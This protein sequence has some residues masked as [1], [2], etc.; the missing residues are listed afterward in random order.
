[1]Y[2]YLLHGVHLVEGGDEGGVH[3]YDVGQRRTAEV[4]E[5]SRQDWDED[6]L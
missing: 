3:S 4:Y 6:M 5:S 1:M 2:T